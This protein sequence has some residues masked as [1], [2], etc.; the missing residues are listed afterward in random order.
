MEGR[1]EKTQSPIFQKSSQIKKNHRFLMDA[2]FLERNTDLALV[3]CAHLF[4]SQ[5]IKKKLQCLRIIIGKLWKE[6]ANYIRR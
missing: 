6:H 2:L 1:R 4:A 3:S 5:T